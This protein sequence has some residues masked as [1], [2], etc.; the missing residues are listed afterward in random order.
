M[1]AGIVIVGIETVVSINMGVLFFDTKFVLKTVPSVSLSNLFISKSDN[2]WSFLILGD[3]YVVSSTVTHSH[4]EKQSSASSILLSSG[5]LIVSFF[6]S[7]YWLLFLRLYLH[8]D[9]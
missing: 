1:N 3:C 7:Y 9:F 4:H 8:T 2:L 5:F 6:V